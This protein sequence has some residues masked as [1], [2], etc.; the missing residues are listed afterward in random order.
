M[1]L[2]IR[3][4][5]SG[6]LDFKTYCEGWS[7]I[8]C[9]GQYYFCKPKGLVERG[10]GCMKT[11]PPEN[12]MG[13]TDGRGKLPSPVLSVLSVLL[14]RVLLHTRETTYGDLSRGLRHTHVRA[15]HQRWITKGKD[16]V[17][18]RRQN[19]CN[20][21]LYALAQK[22]DTLNLQWNDALSDNG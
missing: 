16:V 20:D 17:S 18:V 7:S 8:G 11:S 3:A 19:A 1:P 22:S 9:S 2:L 5:S 12:P 6:V 14:T 15:Y 13:K 4:L 21:S 10:P